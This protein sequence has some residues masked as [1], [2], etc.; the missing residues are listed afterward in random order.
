VVIRKASSKNHPIERL[1]SIERLL[2][3][4]YFERRALELLSEEDYH[5]MIRNL[6]GTRR[7]KMSLLQSYAAE[8]KLEISDMLGEDNQ[9]IPPKY[10]RR[11]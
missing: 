6:A 8:R 1:A 5:A 9:L 4:L 3:E 7:I 2:V 11:N 10:I